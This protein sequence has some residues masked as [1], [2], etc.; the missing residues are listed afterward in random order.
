MECELTHA[1]LCDAQVRFSKA[2]DPEEFAEDAFSRMLEPPELQAMI[3]RIDADLNAIYGRI[4]P[5]LVARYGLGVIHARRQNHPD[6]EQVWMHRLYTMNALFL[7]QRVTRMLRH[8]IALKR[9]VMRVSSAF[10]HTYYAPPDGRGYRASIGRLKQGFK[11][12]TEE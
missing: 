9:F 3:N 1:E 2:S 6:I 11:V 7:R 8:L 10:L 5:H 12:V 4:H